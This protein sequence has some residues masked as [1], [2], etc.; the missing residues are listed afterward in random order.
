MS[1]GSS[2]TAKSPPEAP[3]RGDAFLLLDQIAAAAELAASYWRS[4][5]LAADR[6][7]IV[8]VLT[9]FSQVA[10]VTREAFALAKTLDRQTQT[11][12]RDPG[13]ESA[14]L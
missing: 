10:A 8:T 4:V 7:D 13:R 12:G 1:A 5:A 6:G 3:D 11:E 9:H 2:T 14:A